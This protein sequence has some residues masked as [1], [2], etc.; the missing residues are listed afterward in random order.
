MTLLQFLIR[1]TR[2]L[3]IFVIIPHQ[4]P[5][6]VVQQVVI[7]LHRYKARPAVPFGGVERL[8]ELPGVHG[9]CANIA[10]LA[11]LDD[12]VQRLQRLFDRRRVI[13]SVRD[14]QA[15]NRPVCAARKRRRLL[16]KGFKNC[17]LTFHHRSFPIADCRLQIAVTRYVIR[18]A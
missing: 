5:A 3:E 11:G 1:A 12:I 17:L 8:S 7:I 16:V 14:A 6:P 2:L 18:D 15:S 4:V 13:P 10:R 9:R